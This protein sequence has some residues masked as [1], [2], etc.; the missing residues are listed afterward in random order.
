[1]GYYGF[2]DYILNQLFPKKRKEFKILSELCEHT[3]E[4][5]YLVAFKEICFI[6]DFP[7]EIHVNERGQ[8]NAQDK[9]AMLYR[10]TYALYY[11]N[12]VKVTKEW[13]ET[14]PESFTKEMIMKETNADIRRETIRKVGMDRLTKLLDYKVIDKKHGYELINF[15]VGD[16]RVRPWLKMVNPSIG[17][18]HIEGVNPGTLSVEDAV[19]FRNSLSEFSLPATI[20]GVPF[21]EGEYHQQ[22]DALFFPIKSIPKEA[23]IRKDRVA[24]EGLNRH[25]ASGKDVK[26]Y[27]G[28]IAAKSKTAIKHPEH[29]DTI[30]K[31]NFQVKKVMEYDHWLE[32]SRIVID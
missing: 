32:E 8:L 25:L 12:G 1:M 15:D 21:G 19:K 31:G 14:K 23:K 11:S 9:A 5:H 16:G 2:Y 29:K 22:G 7:K 24:V 26:V 4:I 28:Y 30:L 6:S 13:A 3:Q 18:I 17:T 20:D 27:H 10:D